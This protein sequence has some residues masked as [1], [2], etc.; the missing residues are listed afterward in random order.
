M[1]TITIH[2]KVV[3]DAEMKL[4]T[5]KN[6]P[7]LVAVFTICDIGLPYQ[8][9]KSPLFIQVNYNKEAASL[10]FEYLK[11]GKEILVKGMLQQKFKRNDKTGEK[12]VRYFI[13]ADDVELLPV[14]PSSSEQTDNKGG[15]E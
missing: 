8:R 9:A 5:V 13:F 11:K 15:E 12:E 3:K 4:I 7:M 10:I 14:F 1:N 6:E 2:G